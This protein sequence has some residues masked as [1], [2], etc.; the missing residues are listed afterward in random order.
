M[1][2]YSNVHRWDF[3]LSPGSLELVCFEIA[4]RGLFN[5]WEDLDSFEFKI[6]SHIKKHARTEKAI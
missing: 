5:Q 4:L 6:K 1:Y 3:G 2:L